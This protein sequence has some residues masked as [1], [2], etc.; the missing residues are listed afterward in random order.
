MEGGHGLTGGLIGG[1]TGGLIGCWMNG[2]WTETVLRPETR[3]GQTAREQL[4][5]HAASMAVE[6]TSG[7]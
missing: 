1:L 2:F 4:Q 7:T 6:S 5:V 3:M